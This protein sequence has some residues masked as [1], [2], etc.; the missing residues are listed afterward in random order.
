[1]EIKRSIEESRNHAEGALRQAQ[2]DL[3]RV[4][5]G[6]T[7]GEFTASLSHELNQPI[8]AAVTNANTC[9]RWLKRDH[10]D[11]EE[12]REAA[13]RVVKDATRAAEIISRVGLLFRKGLCN[14]SWWM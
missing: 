3:S 5:R 11:V 12:A 13:S 10:P 4:S 7:M 2:A 9:L 6:T 14:R 1:M 8:A